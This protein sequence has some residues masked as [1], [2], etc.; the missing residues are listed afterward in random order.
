MR[1]YEIVVEGYKEVRQKFLNDADAEHVD[2]TIKQY[3]DLVNRNQVHGDEK[4][5]DFWG[6]RGWKEF[7]SF[8]N[9]KSNI[10]SRSQT[11]RKKVDNN[12]EKIWEND[13]W[14]A[15]VPYDRHTSCQ[16]GKGTGWCTA[17]LDSDHFKNYVHTDEVVLVYFLNKHN[18]DKWAAA[19]Y[20]EQ[21][22]Q[23]SFDDDFDDDFDDYGLDDF[24]DEEFSTTIF[25]KQDD[26][27]QPNDFRSATGINIDKIVDLVNHKG[28]RLRVQSY[29]KKA[30]NKET[31]V[32][33]K[34]RNLDLSERDPGLENEIIDSDHE[35]SAA[36][37]IKKIY[38]LMGKQSYPR[39]LSNLAIRKS[40]LVYT[41]IDNPSTS[42]MKTLIR[43]DPLQLG[44][45]DNP[46]DDVVQMAI[47][48]EPRAIRVAKRFNT[49]HLEYIAGKFPKMLLNLPGVEQPIRSGILNRNPEMLQWIKEPTDKDKFVAVMSDPNAIKYVENPGPD[50][51]E[52][53]PEDIL[54][55]HQI[56]S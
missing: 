4:N 56:T 29:V 6:K 1:Y 27:V 14:E 44:M 13:E 24:P 23:Y 12:S 48:A 18:D 9:E 45:I 35:P 8:V 39:E 40:P 53:V 25:N 3:K 30:K 46:P 22:E 20:P 42:T 50:L 7:E 33:N 26:Q 17:I 10:R 34:I 49:K 31:N 32:L 52:L 51:L 28:V 36:K 2:K 37:Y 15:V 41:M 11:R 21:S 16:L 43:K 19:I 55:K 38:E 47:E 5:I 54:R